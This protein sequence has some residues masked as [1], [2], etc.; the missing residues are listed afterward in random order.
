M[1]PNSSQ[2]ILAREVVL[3]FLPG[4]GLVHDVSR[5]ALVSNM[6]ISTGETDVKWSDGS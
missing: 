6:T 5:I 4:R 3:S 1:L 2:R